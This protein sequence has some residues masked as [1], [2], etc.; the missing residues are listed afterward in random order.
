[1]FENAISGAVSMLVFFFGV[2]IAFIIF[3][4]YLWSRVRKRVLLE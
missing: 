2:S 4:G 3:S 1:M